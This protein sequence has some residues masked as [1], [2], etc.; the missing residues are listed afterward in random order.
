MT[1]IYGHRG[2]RG[3]RPENTIEGFLH[4]KSL[5]LAGVECDVALTR[6]LVP[7]L[8]HDPD[9]S[10]GTFICDLSFEQVHLLAPHIPTLA[11]GLRSAPALEW[12]IEI[13]TFPDAPEKTC[14]PEAMVEAVLAALESSG[15]LHKAC[16]LAFDWR[17]LSA[18][19]RYAPEVR[20]IC[21]TAP[22]TEQA[23]EIWWGRDIKRPLPE[24]VAQTSA[25]GWAPFHAEVTTAQIA[26]A[27]RLGLKVFPWTVNAPADFARLAPIADGIIT[28]FPSRYRR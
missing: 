1:A 8:N 10:P 21:L 15:M 13:K 12:L 18:M 4:A 5:E 3:E 24:A 19:T 20:R 9:V 17:I 25:Y 6:D 23:R 26:Q 7:V 22:A 14:S 2:G 11:E 27:H 16:I 28:D